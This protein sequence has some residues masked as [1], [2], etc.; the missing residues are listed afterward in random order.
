MFATA[1]DRTR[2]RKGEGVFHSFFSF[3]FLFVLETSK[4]GST[5][6]TRRSIVDEQ[7]TGRGGKET[8]EKRS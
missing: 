2:T 5:S 6:T 8:K 1:E 7:E 3:H 4:R